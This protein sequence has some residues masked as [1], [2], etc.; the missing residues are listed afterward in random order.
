M[1]RI[2]IILLSTQ[3]LLGICPA[4]AENQCLLQCKNI[5][6]ITCNEKSTDENCKKINISREE[7]PLKS[8]LNESYKAYLYTINNN[9]TNSVE[10][11]KIYRFHNPQKIIQEF[12]TKR[13]YDRF[14]IIL[15]NPIFGTIFFPFVWIYMGVDPSLNDPNGLKSLR[16][17]IN[18]AYIMPVVN[19]A[20]APYYWMTD[21]LSDEKAYKESENIIKEFKN[22]SIKPNQKTQFIALVY[23]NVGEFLNLQRLEFQFKD[24]STQKIYRIEK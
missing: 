7:V 18:W 22:I 19:T 2:L 11:I 21:P 13:K 16:L 8:Y 4:C 9:Q 20:L 24:Y 1:K 15:V 5:E 12:K 6:I 10:I 17:A 23:K 14:P 3:I